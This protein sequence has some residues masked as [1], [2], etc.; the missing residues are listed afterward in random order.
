MLKKTNARLDELLDKN[1]AEKSGKGY[2]LVSLVIVFFLTA[3]I[4]SM[5]WY[6]YDSYQD[7]QNDEILIISADEEE[8]KIEP[9]DP[10]GMVVDNIDKAVYGVL[11]GS[12]SKADNKEKVLPPA[13]EPIDKNSLKKEVQQDVELVVEEKIEQKDDLAVSGDSIK[14]KESPSQ[15]NKVSQDNKETPHYK[16]QIASFKSPEDTQK[17]W[18]SLSKKFPQL[19]GSYQHYIVTKNIEGKGIYHRLQIGP[20]TSEKEARDACNALKENGLNCFLIKP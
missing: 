5:A 1:F 7:K 14:P 4:I 6:L 17:E 9:T 12:D 2:S 19:I 8:I 3:I 15:D 10:G 18:D 13:E 11:D 20:F 16:V